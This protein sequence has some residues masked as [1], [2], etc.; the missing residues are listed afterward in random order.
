MKLTIKLQDA[1]LCSINF[2]EDNPGGVDSFF[3][4]PI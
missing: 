2:M 1:E 4:L 3:P